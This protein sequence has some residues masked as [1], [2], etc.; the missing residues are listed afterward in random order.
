MAQFLKLIIL[1][2]FGSIMG[3]SYYRHCMVIIG[4]LMNVMSSGRESQKRGGDY[5]DH[6]AWLLTYLVADHRWHYKDIEEAGL[7]KCGIL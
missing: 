4:E 7:E 1:A 2:I 6:N 3:I 5:K